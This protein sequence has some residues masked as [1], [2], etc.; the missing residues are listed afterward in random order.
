MMGNSAQ[1]LDLDAGFVLDEVSVH[2]RQLRIVRHDDEVRVEP[3]VMAILVELARRP[4]EVVRRDEFADSVWRG[5]IVSDE[6]LS[7]NISVLRSALGDDARAPRFIQTVPTVGYRLVANLSAL[8]GSADGSHPLRPTLMALAVA[9]LVIIGLSAWWMLKPGPHPQLPP[10]TVAVLPFEN[11]SE[12]PATEY[13]SDG[14]TDEV[15]GA[16]A[17]AQGLLVVAR[18]SSFAFRNRREDVRSIGAT[19]GA[20]SILEGSVRRS[21]DRLRVSANLVSANDGLQLWSE[22]FETE[23]EDVFEVQNRIARA[24][25]GRL[26]GTLAPEV[27]LSRQDTSDLAAFELYLRANHQL[28]HRGPAA[29]SRSIELFEQAIALDPDFARAHVG[30]AQA[31]AMLPTYLDEI[32]L[33]YLTKARA[34]LE[35]AQALGHSSARLLGTLAYVSFREWRWVEAQDYFEQALALTPTDSDVRQ[36][37]SQFLGTVGKIPEALDEALAAIQSDPLS[38]VAHQRLAVVYLWVDDLEQARSHMATADQLGLDELATPEA[39]IAL[40]A[41]AGEF[42]AVDGEL[43]VLQRQRNLPADWIDTVLT[44]VRGEGGVPDAI[45]AL[46]DAY[47]SG[48][49]G[50]RLFLGALYFIGNEQG[51]FDGLDLLIDQHAAIDTE[52]LFTPIAEHLRGTPRFEAAMARMGIAA[53]WRER[54][55]PAL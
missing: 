12:T 24:I 36:Q 47:T 13:F 3:K 9:V 48:A 55:A 39:F 31:H 52:L 46:D 54:G 49:I 11:L 35:R 44:A 37:Y 17:R 42:G 43:R 26:V 7:H 51:F 41:R 5:R 8:D 6:V 23:L 14:L 25:V 40:L 22:T 20:G 45:G 33:P 53:Y 27:T 19:L 38:G 15:T 16:L 18:T 34:S 2:P 50:S 30:L 28:Y 1:E 4:G 32:E 29:V 21:G 10:T